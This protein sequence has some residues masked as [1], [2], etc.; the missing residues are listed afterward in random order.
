MQVIS[1]E[2]KGRKI[3][4]FVSSEKVQETG[5]LKDSKDV[6]SAASL[7][8]H[9]LRLDTKAGWLAAFKTEEAT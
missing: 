8:G 7:G 6:T 1:G 5:N 3:L 2:I 4:R 9:R